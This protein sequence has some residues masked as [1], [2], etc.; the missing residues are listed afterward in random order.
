MDAAASARTSVEG[1]DD[2]GRPSG[3]SPS[4]GAAHGVRGLLAQLAQT[5]IVDVEGLWDVV[6]DV[7]EREQTLGRLPPAGTQHADRA[8]LSAR[9]E[10]RT[11]RDCLTRCSA[12]AGLGG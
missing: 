11:A 10:L 4:D 6:E 1:G 2:D 9:R 7:V 5:Q 3:A 12:G 8:V